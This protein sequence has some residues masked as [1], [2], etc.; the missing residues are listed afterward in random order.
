VS[1]DFDPAAH[2]EARAELATPSLL[3]LIING[4]SVL[5][6]FGGLFSNPSSSQVRGWFVGMGIEP[7][8]SS[9]MLM[10][11]F[12]GFPTWPGALIG[13]VVAAAALYGA[14]KMRRAEGYGW[15][16]ACAVLSVFPSCFC[17]CGNTPIAIW[18]LVVLSRPEVRAGFV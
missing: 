17:C 11:Q 1:L 18:A 13:I 9:D 16:I 6:A 8:A 14:L 10:R 15:A 5:T 12:D 2:D 7:D 3:L 4:L